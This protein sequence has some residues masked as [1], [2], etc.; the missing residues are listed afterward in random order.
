MANF[1]D[2]ET[3][4]EFALVVRGGR[5]SQEDAYKLAHDFQVAFN[6]WIKNEWGLDLVASQVTYSDPGEAIDDG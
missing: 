3:D 2:K 6:K 4:V 5:E 1:Y